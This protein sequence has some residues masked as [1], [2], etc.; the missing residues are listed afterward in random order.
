MPSCSRRRLPDDGRELP[1]EQRPI[2]QGEEHA[3]QR[4]EIDHVAQID[5]ATAHALE[6]REHTDPGGD[7]A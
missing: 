4:Q 2:G 6:M 7:R 1:A 5:H 3:G